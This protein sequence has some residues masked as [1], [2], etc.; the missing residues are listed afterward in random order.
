MGLGKTIQAIALMVSRRSSDPARKTNLLV[1]PVAL[2]RQWEAEI[3]T[4]L[5]PDREHRL[6]TY[7]YHGT[8]RITTWENL[9]KYDVVITTYGTLAAEFKRK[10]RIDGLKKL[11]PN[12][13]S[14]SAK[15]KLPVLG[16]ECKFHR[17][18]LD[19]AQNIKNKATKSAQATVSY[20]ILPSANLGLNV[21]P[22][23]SAGHDE[24]GNEWYPHAK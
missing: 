4:K 23:L 12:W 3:K 21:L 8:G 14:F 6:S 2:L 22:V 1:A 16:D 11:N 9:R 15:D 17:I 5:K 10:Q 24:G 18:I 13:I 19:E 20:G 7:L